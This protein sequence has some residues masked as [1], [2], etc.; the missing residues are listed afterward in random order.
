M[1]R[2]WGCVILLALLLSLSLLNGYYI[3]QFTQRLAGHLEQSQ[4]LAQQGQWSRAADLTKLAFT[5]W[6]EEHF[7]LHTTMRHADTDQILRSFHGVLQYLELQEMDQY[8]A[9]NA[10]LIILLRLLAET[11]QPS[12]VNIL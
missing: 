3:E 6:Q 10:E 5:Q 11:E 9:A 8:A 1:K 7:Y 12:L 4:T 2:L